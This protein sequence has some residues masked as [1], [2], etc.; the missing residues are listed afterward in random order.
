MS[1]SIRNAVLAA[2]FFAVGTLGTLSLSAVAERGPRGQSKMAMLFEGVDLTEAQQDQVAEMT[3]AM[4]AERKE[5]RASKGDKLGMLT[6][7]L[8]QETVDRDAVYAEI[9]Q[10]LAERRELMVQRAD[11][12]MDFAETLD[13]DQRAAL[14]DNVAE[15]QARVQEHLQQRE[16]E[17]S[18][19]S[20]GPERP[21]RRRGR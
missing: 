6:D 10:R 3:E 14:L 15:M 18:E 12:L 21:E 17:G 19:G 16:A 5:Y 13:E 4:R 20:E 7:V 8:S 2:G 11:A 1:R 9:D